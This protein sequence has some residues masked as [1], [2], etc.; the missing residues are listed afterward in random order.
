MKCGRICSGLLAMLL[1][2]TFA[3]AAVADGRPPLATVDELERW[4]AVGRVSLGGFKSKGLCSGTLIAP[5]KVITAAHCVHDSKTG[6]PFPPYRL[7]FI[8]GWHLGEYRAAAKAKSVVV[9]PAYRPDQVRDKQITQRSLIGSDLGLITLAEP[10]A[11]VIPLPL[12]ASDLMIPD[13]QPVGLMGYRRDR[14]YALS[15]YQNCLA[16]PRGFTLLSLNC[17]VISGTS[18]APVM[19]EQADGWALI[20]VISSRVDG[21]NPLERALAARADT[22]ALRVFA[23]D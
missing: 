11:D 7:T 19:M 16:R 23:S 3:G 2:I 6:Q 15:S 17:K 20:G 4:Q 13:D 1:G 8:A 9:H 14:P 21:N 22:A 12:A 10:L 5:D 18:G